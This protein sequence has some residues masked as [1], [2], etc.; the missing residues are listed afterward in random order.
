MA[1]TALSGQLT[2]ET[3]G[4]RPCHQMPKRPRRWAAPRLGRRPWWH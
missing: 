3:K 4:S 1:L 2:S